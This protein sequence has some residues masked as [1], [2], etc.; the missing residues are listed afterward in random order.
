MLRER[1]SEEEESLLSAEESQSRREQP[2]CALLNPISAGIA[3]DRYFIN[4]SRRGEQRNFLLVTLS[5]RLSARSPPAVAESPCL[6]SPF[7]SRVTLSDRLIAVVIVLFCDDYVTIATLLFG[8]LSSG[9]KN[10][11]LNCIT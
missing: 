2:R 10:G 3:I 1:V 9:A 8:T 4:I 6:P 7:L 11:G 5:D